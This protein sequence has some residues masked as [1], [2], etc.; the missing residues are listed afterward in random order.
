[1]AKSLDELI[2]FLLGEIALS[3]LSGKYLVGA[4]VATSY[5]LIPKVCEGP[6]RS[7]TRSTDILAFPPSGSITWR[8]MTDHRS[9]YRSHHRWPR[10]SC[11][12]VL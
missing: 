2:E 7:P 10:E 1:M 8:V 9:V 4:K 11:V 6:S 5:S 12:I 3:G